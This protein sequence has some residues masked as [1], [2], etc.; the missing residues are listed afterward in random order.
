MQRKSTFARRNAFTLI[1][2]LVV[3]AIIAILAAILFPVF[4]RAR[5]NA[6]R[7]SCQSNLKQLG[8]GL[9][10]YSQDYDGGI[11][12][13][14]YTP[15]GGA[16]TVTWAKLYIPLIDYVKN[17]QI[18]RCPSAPQA[19]KT[20][21]PITSFQGSTYGFP[22][23]AVAATG[24]AALDGGAGAKLDAVPE[25]SRTCM[26]GETMWNPYY[27]NYGYGSAQFNIAKPISVDPAGS[28]YHL[29]GGIHLEGIN[30]LYVDGHVKWLSANAVTSSVNQ[31][32]AGG[33][34]PI[35]AP[36]NV[37]IVFCWQ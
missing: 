21:A 35:A 32:N 10:M 24:W 34:A 18:F 11:V 26:L 5:E 23:K 13:Y 15:P 12:P 25:A 28:S 30:F 29:N 19:S 20:Y 33:C 3:I 8:L 2:L 9:I 1:E 7:A 27:D 31:A 17:D 14:G 36:P 16:Y 4:A 6:R 22:Y 37:P